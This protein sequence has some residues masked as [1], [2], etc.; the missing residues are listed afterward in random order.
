M[1]VEFSLALTSGMQ[2]QPSPHGWVYGVSK[3]QLLYAAMPLETTFNM[4]EQT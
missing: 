1:L 3:Q 2:P 4:Q